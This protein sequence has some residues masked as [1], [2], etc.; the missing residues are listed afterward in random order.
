M[1]NC[2]TVTPAVLINQCPTT[3][4]TTGGGGQI[5]G[6]KRLCSEDLANGAENKRP[7]IV[8]SL[9]MSFAKSRREP[10][11]LRHPPSA[12]ETRQLRRH[13]RAEIARRAGEVTRLG[14]PD[15]A[16]A[17]SKTFRQLARIAGAA[18][19]GEGFYVRRVV[20]HGDVAELAKR[21]AAMSVSERGE[22]PVGQ[23]GQ[24]VPGQGCRRHGPGRTGPRPCPTPAGPGHR[25]IM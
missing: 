16:V 1:E 10:C 20:S 21:L 15:R 19:S 9:E 24:P 2:L 6:N 13:V 25:V 23:P 11:K 18:P 8:P 22:L 17:T 12:D 7:L 14:P 4:T 5:N 3:S